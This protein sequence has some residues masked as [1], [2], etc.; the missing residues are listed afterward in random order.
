MYPQAHAH[1]GPQ[2][3]AH[4]GPKTQAH[5][6]PQAHAHMSPK[7]QAHNVPKTPTHGPKNTPICISKAK[8]LT[9]SVLIIFFTTTIVEKKPAVSS[10]QSINSQGHLTFSFP[11]LLNTKKKLTRSLTFHSQTTAS[12]DLRACTKVTSSLGKQ[13]P[14][15]LLLYILGRLPHPFHIPYGIILIHSST[16]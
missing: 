4:M 2:A 7:T 16:I 9:K 8:A 11:D 14:V 1:L 15:N 13:N 6:G 3:H 5:I 12:S 10:F